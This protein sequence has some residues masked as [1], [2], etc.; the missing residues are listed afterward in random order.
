MTSDG[1]GTAGGL[2]AAILANV[3][4]AIG[5]WLVRLAETGPVAT[6]F[7]RLALAM[8]ALLIWSAVA[9]P[10]ALRRGLAFWPVL[11]VAGLAFAADL[12]TW[13][14]SIHGTTLANATLFA[15]SATLIYPIYGFL[16]ARAWPSRP[17]IAALLLAAVGGGMLLG[18]SAELS[19]AHLVGDLL[20]LFAGL[21]YA[22]YFIGMARVRAVVPPMPALALSGVATMAPLLVLA[23]GLG[24]QLVPTG[25]ASWGPLIALALVSQVFGQGL[26]IYA[27]GRL[28]PLV[29][30][31]TLLLQPVVAGGIGWAVYGERPGTPDWIGALLVAAALVLVRREPKVAPAAGQTRSVG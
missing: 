6:G 2:A 23:I 7:W 5:P 18:Q 12:A 15:N 11:L 14:V 10:G 25:A 13:N 21:A 20:A 31:I 1:R 8:P 29:I 3:A 16:I 19:H 24:E 4:L 22:V 27:L 26:M 17:Q 30:G 9:T 28:P